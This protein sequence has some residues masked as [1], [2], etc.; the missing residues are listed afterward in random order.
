M[1]STIILISSL[2]FCGFS[3]AFAEAIPSGSYVEPMTIQMIE[4]G[5][6]IG[7]LLR[8]LSS[9]YA[10]EMTDTDRWLFALLNDRLNSLHTSDA[11]QDLKEALGDVNKYL[12]F[13]NALHG[14][15]YGITTVPPG[16]PDEH[17]AREKLEMLIDATGN[18]GSLLSQA[19]VAYPYY[20]DNSVLWVCIAAN[21]NDD[22]SPMESPLSYMFCQ[23]FP[24]LNCIVA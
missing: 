3:P 14:D 11:W 21:K 1:A 9:K 13:T 4:I 15:Y 17:K 22:S 8:I 18:K 16:L 6:E 2:L 23:R 12:Q 5:S 10:A 24:W 20:A 7:S 19:L